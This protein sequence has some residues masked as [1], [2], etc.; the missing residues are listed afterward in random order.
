MEKEQEPDPHECVRIVSQSASSGRP[1][2]LARLDTPGQTMR[3]NSASGR[4]YRR[5]SFLRQIMFGGEQ[6]GYSLAPQQTSVYCAGR[7]PHLCLP[8]GK[9]GAA[10]LL[11]LM[12]FR[13][14]GGPRNLRPGAIGQSVLFAHLGPI[15]LR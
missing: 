4:V 5:P 8:G 13:E 10:E 12:E 9:R 15:I 3:G 2:L 7:R 14:G 1:A 6:R 11:T